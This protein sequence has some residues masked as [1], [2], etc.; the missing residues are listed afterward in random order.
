M[1]FGVGC[2]HAFRSRL[3]EIGM[4]R[5]ILRFLFLQFATASAGDVLHVMHHVPEHFRSRFELRFERGHRRA[6]NAGIDAAINIDRPIAAMQHA[7]R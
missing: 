7:A 5:Q 1:S 3:A 4:F 2:G 6:V